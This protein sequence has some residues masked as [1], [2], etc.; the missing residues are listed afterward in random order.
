MNN[1]FGLFNKS[2][3]SP[4]TYYFIISLMIFVISA[5]ITGSVALAYPIILATRG[6]LKSAGFI[7]FYQL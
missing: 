6:N 5:L 1:V 4:N 7:L 3:P 2:P